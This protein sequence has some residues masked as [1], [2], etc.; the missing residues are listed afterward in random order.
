MR[1]ELAKR[2]TVEEFVDKF[3][4]P[5][6]V[7][8]L[9]PVVP[10]AGLDE[11]QVATI[12]AAQLAQKDAADKQQSN[13]LQ[14]SATLAE[15]FGDAANTVVKDKAKELGMSVEKLKSLSADN[16]TLVLNLFEGVSTSKP[17]PITPTQTTPS[18]TDKGA[19][20]ATADSKLVSPGLTQSELLT[21]WGNI[22]KRVHDR[23][24]VQS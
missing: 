9:P 14:V 12:F 19:D 18:Y 16:P 5:T 21:G 23:N 6:N 24:G 13:V 8:D 1:E 15:K 17:Q 2:K 4:A 3:T 11:T 22:K 10:A 20:P 7:D